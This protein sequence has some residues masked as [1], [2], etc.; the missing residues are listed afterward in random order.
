MSEQGMD[1]PVDP[2]VEVSGK[3]TMKDNI[4]DGGL[5]QSPQQFRS[6]NINTEQPKSPEEEKIQKIENAWLRYNVLRGQKGETIT[7]DEIN[8]QKIFKDQGLMPP[9]TREAVDLIEKSADG[10]PFTVTPEM[11]RILEENGI[12]RENFGKSPQELI[13]MLKKDRLEQPAE[14]EKFESKN[15]QDL[16]KKELKSVD[17]SL[18]QKPEDAKTIPGSAKDQQTRPKTE[19]SKVQEKKAKKKNVSLLEKVKKNF[20]LRYFLFGL[21]ALAWDKRKESRKETKT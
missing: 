2:T 10:V 5:N 15:P 19:N 3:T 13:E 21:L 7:S 11:G 8:N 6:E 18:V 12:S 16:I 9:L 17:E 20:K 1:I 4:G 14:Q